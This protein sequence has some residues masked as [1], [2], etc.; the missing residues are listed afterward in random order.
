MSYRYISAAEA[1]NYIKNGMSIAL[2]GFTPAGYPKAVCPEI[3]KI[4]IEE[5]KCGKP[6]K[7]NL[8]TGAS[9]GDSVDGVLSR[10]DAINYRAPYTT[11]KDFRHAV[12]EGRIHYKDLHLSEMAQEL[13]FGFWG[14]V[15]IAIIEACCITD[16][17]KIYLTTGGGIAP[18]IARMSKG[19]II[20]LNHFQSE[21]LIGM[22]DVYELQ[23]PILHNEIPIYN[24]NDRI[25]KTYVE[26]DPKKIIGIVETNIP[27]EAR[28]FRQSDPVTDQIGRNIA[29]FLAAD[30][31]KGIIPSTFLP[32]QSGVGNIGNAV[33]SA[34]GSS[35][36]IPPFNMFSEVIQDSVIKLMREGRIK[37]CSTS[38]LTL[39]TKCLQGVYDDMD[40]FRDKFVLRESEVSNSAELIKRFGV[41]SINTALEADIYGNINS[42]HVMG[43]MMMNGIG[44]S[45]DFTHN[46]Y[47]A[48][49]A[50]PSTAKDGLISSIVPM[51]P[52][53][54]HTEHSV[55]VIVTENGVA[56]LR[57]KD[58][59]QRAEL[60]IE[61]CAH[62]SYRG[63]LRDYVKISKHHGHTPHSLSKAFAF[64]KAFMKEGDMHL[65]DFSN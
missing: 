29:E 59:Q 54:D 30:M 39:T 20:E 49:F 42:T 55:D 32:I 18:T 13:R 24:L 6:Y 31:K 23:N 53:I 1:A 60:I 46:A 9:T 47:I 63:I 41:I 25:G 27:D 19:I 2:S 44:G 56:D 16:D 35:K 33:M 48:I 61:N 50:T 65:A 36:V 7:I 57:G 28:L 12:N 52:H 51:S 37:F 64:H 45:G 5:H 17:G 22:H 34:M 26:V 14:K 40:F 11:N 58:P 15:D 8:F 10:A 3:A 38:A 4:A 21:K 43:T 62:P